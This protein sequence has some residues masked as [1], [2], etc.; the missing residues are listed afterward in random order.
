MKV[1]GSSV[2][3]GLLYTLKTFFGTYAEDFRRMGNKGG[4][5]VEDSH[6]LR[7][8]VEGVVTVHYP[9]APMPI[10][11]TYERFRVLPMLVYD[12]PTPGEKDVRC[13][14]CGICAKV[15]PPQCIWI[16]QDSDEKGKPKPNAKE[17]Y[18]DTAVCMNCGMCS[19]FCPFDAI[20]MDH[21]FALNVTDKRR[22]NYLYD[23]DKLLVPATYYAELHPKAN[24]QEEA[25]RK[26]EAEAKAAKEAA[27]KE[28]AAKKA[29]EAKVLA[30]TGAT[31]ETETASAKAE[32]PERAARIAA[33]K[34]KAAEAKAQKEA[35]AAAASSSPVAET[36][37][38][39]EDPERAARIAAAKAKAAAAKEAKAQKEAELT[40]VEH[41]LTPPSTDLPPSVVAAT[42]K[43]Q[44]QADQSAVFSDPAPANELG[45]APQ[46][47]PS[48]GT[49]DEIP[50]PPASEASATPD[51]LTAGDEAAAVTPDEPSVPA[52]LS[53]AAIA[54]AEKAQFEAEAEAAFSDPAPANE[55][56][57]APQVAPSSG[58]ESEI[59]PP[60]ASE[61]TS[62]P[63]TLTAG[64][65]AAQKEKR[66]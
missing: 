4:T 15:C 18:I 37:P 17:F 11:G 39:T 40:A 52:P 48:S 1:Y 16:V 59:Q 25:A 47:A 31:A 3:K 43:A 50:P 10:G 20:K 27:K 49:E 58:T 28:A 45:Q 29:A 19:E 35:A 41:P 21:Q 33:A 34:A 54:S 53:D 2:L 7:S 57:Q 66:S 64:D 23:L 56:G 51:T 60:P 6:G 63:D 61:A 8:H 62:T 44:E 46:L 36:P 22:E 26:A 32:D 13:T 65:E 55:L 12:E 38:K 30:Q 5:S 9:E 24:A 42:E 14:A